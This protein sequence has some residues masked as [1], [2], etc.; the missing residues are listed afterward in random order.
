MAC[1]KEEKFILKFKMLHMYVLP[2]WE[3]YDKRHVGVYRVQMWSTGVKE[4]NEELM[5][6]R[7]LNEYEYVDRNDH[8][9]GMKVTKWANIDDE[10]YTNKYYRAI[11]YKIIKKAIEE[12]KAERM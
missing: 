7:E 6:V 11:I 1:E 12:G 8:S 4:A 9:K 5:K 2:M 3:D 10:T